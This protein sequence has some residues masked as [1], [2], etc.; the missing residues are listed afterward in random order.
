MSGGRPRDPIWEF[1]NERQDLGEGKTEQNVLRARKW[2]L[3]TP[4]E[5]CD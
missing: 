2:W 1:F 5:K 4:N 3:E